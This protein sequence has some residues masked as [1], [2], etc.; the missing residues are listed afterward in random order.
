[1]SET[2]IKYSTVLGPQEGLIIVVAV[3]AVSSVLALNA[4]VLAPYC[5]NGD[6]ITIS[7]PDILYY[8]FSSNPAAVADNTATAGVNQVA[9][10]PALQP[11]RLLI[12][13]GMP[14]LALQCPTSVNAR[15]WASSATLA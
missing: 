13:K 7:C 14:Y 10:M 1:M 11:Q 4:G 12:P 2:A 5:T 15:L 3:S 8:R 9:L 6:Y